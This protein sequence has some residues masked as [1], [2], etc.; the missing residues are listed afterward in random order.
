MDVAWLIVDSLSYSATPFASDAPDTMPRFAELADSRGV[1]FDE[2]YVPGPSSPSSHSA[3]FTGKL[4]SE[5]GMHEARPYFD[6]DLRTIA[7]ALSDHRSFMISSNPFIFNGLDRDFDE[8]DDLRRGQYKV[9]EDAGDPEM[10]AK[11]HDFDSSLRQ[12]LAFLRSSGK[13]VRSLANGIS[14]KR[15]QRRETAEIPKHAAGDTTTYQYANTINEGVRSFRDRADGDSFVVANYMDVH[16]PLDAS[17]EA[18]ERFCP[19]TPRSELPIGVRGQDVYERFHAEDDYDAS[20]MYDLYKA[21]IYDVDRKLTPLVEELLDDG[22]FVVVTADHGIWFR[23]QREFDD[24]RV[25]VP[26]VVFAPGEDPR[27]VG[28]TVNLLA[29]PQTTMRAV[30]GNDGGFDGYDLFDVSSDQ[31]SVTEFIHDED[32]EGTP[33]NPEGTDA[34]RTLYDI[35][36]IRGDAR[37]EYTGGRFSTVDGKSDTT[38]DLKRHVETLLSEHPELGSGGG[39]EYDDEVRERLEDFGYL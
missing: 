14:F 31:T 21:T 17:D 22:T 38:D 34:G 24:E 3:F 1:V 28:H 39:I 16:P 32:V 35:A 13:P 36:A 26:L 19:D 11:Q 37:V 20:D 5:T 18:L 2:A 23:R 4:P 29:L 30:A 8:T 15:W 9:F 10:F 6:S 33:V 12:M 25:H 27:R 7:G